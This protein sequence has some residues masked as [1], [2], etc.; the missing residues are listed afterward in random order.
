MM[1]DALHSIGASAA[2]LAV[3]VVEDDRF[4]RE[5]VENFLTTTGF[6]VHAVNSASALNDLLQ[7][8]AIHLYV[9]DVNLPG[10]N[11]LSLS[12]RLRNQLPEAGI[13]I[14]SGRHTL[15]DRIKGYEE[16]GADFYFTKPAE[17]HELEMVLRG[18]ARR[19]NPESSDKTWLLRLSNRILLSPYSSQPV[20]LTHREKK[21]LIALIQA[22]DNTLESWELCDLLS[23][24]E[25]DSPM[26]KHSLEEFI[27]RLRKKLANAL[28]EGA[29]DPIKSVWSLGY[30]LCITIV[31]K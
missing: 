16:G 29:E 21:F 10:E 6:V 31:L 1:N 7:S 24:S 30:Q 9:I 18:L 26:S 23:D 22:K 3:A 17:P 8:V 19:I 15:L 20:R 2:P 11:G 12:R 4:L 28:G 13:V 25:K 14:M 27:R 5:E